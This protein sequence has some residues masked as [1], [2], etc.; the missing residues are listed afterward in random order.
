MNARTMAATGPV[1]LQALVAFLVE[2]RLPTPATIT[3]PSPEFPR[4]EVWLATPHA[5]VW[6]DA[7]GVT[8]RSEQTVPALARG[9]FRDDYE[10]VLIDATIPS[11][12]GDVAVVFRYIRRALA[13]APLRVVGSAS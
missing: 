13:P 4:M 2:H 7:P 11:P 9:D 10:S 5:T 1:A 3:P 8:I 6:L 12:L